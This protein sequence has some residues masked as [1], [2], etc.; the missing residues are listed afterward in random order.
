M[1][2]VRVAGTGAAAATFGVPG[3][4]ANT[5]VAVLTAKTPGTYGNNLRVQ[6]TNADERAHILN[7]VST[8]NTS[9]NYGGV[10]SVQGGKVAVRRAA[11]HK[12]D[13][14]DVLFPTVPPP[15]TPVV[16]AVGQV[17]LN[18]DTGALTFEPT[19][20]PVAGDQLLAT[21]DVAPAKARKVTLSL[22]TV[23]ER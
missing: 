12:V 22:G 14:F 17:V 7:E 6:V 8:S 4:T 2:A 1:I 19:Q 9:L 20:K 18:P 23:V 15:A 13:T 21:Y 5:F 11:T 10:A 3:E 16:P